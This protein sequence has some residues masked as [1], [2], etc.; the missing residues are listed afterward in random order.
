MIIEIVGGY[1]SNSLAILSDA[2]HMATDQ[3]GLFI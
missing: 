1:M 3:L 2:A